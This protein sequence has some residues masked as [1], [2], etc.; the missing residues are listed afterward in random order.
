MGVK[1]GDDVRERLKALGIVKERTPH[2]LMKKAI[3]E[4]LAKEEVS[5]REKQEDLARWQ[6][7]QDTGE[8]LG[9]DEV[10]TRLTRLAD[11]ART[12]AAG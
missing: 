6:R 12:K 11:Q 5:E 9:H 4:Y 10:R 8:H 7:Y 2:F 1:L 3:E